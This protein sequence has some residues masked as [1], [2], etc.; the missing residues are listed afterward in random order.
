M[1]NKTFWPMFDNLHK[2]FV[3]FLFYFLILAYIFRNTVVFFLKDET[4][5]VLLS[6]LLGEFCFYFVVYTGVAVFMS[7][8]A[9]Q[10]KY[11]LKEDNQAK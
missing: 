9:Y 11:V 1:L 8:L 6:G 4:L 7:S 3:W 10:A 2:L 5:P